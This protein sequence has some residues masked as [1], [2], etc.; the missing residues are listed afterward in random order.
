MELRYLRQRW[1]YC[2]DSCLPEAFY[3]IILCTAPNR[4][5]YC[6]GNIIIPIAAVDE[7]LF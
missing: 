4:V 5:Q 2:A 7:Y 1:R 6:D 3:N